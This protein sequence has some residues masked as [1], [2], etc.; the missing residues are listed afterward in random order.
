MKLS[1]IGSLFLFATHLHQLESIGEVKKLKNLVSM[2]LAVS[3]DRESDR[4]LFNRKLAEGS[5]S[6]LYG[7]EFARWLHM[8]REF[9]DNAEEIRKKLAND[10]TSIETLSKKKKR[11]K[12]NKELYLVKCSICGDDVDDTHHIAQQKDANETGH[13]GHFHKDHRYNLIPL[14]K[15]HHDM[16][17]DGRL[18]I[19]GFVMTD[20]GLELHYKE[21]E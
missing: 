8:D 18:R 11:S 20:K 12:Y 7:L 2:H 4:L 9:L 3:Y 13:V 14:C 1:G 5:G 15:K 16:V 10:Y 19:N 17:H 6:T 21:E